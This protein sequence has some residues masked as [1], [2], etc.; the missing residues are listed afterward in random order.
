MDR[1]DPDYLWHVANGTI[2]VQEPERK[3]AEELVELRAW[4]RKAGESL[5][6]F[7]DDFHS[8]TSPDMG[9]D[10]MHCP[11]GDVEISGRLHHERCCVALACALLAEEGGRS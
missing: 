4:K 2:S 1:V 9:G 11:G 8:M 5:Q 7:F 3:M 10:C 6:E